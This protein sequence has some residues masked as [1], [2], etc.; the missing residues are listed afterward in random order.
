MKGVFYP[1]KRVYC[2][3]SGISRDEMARIH[4]AEV[5]AA[6][7]LRHGKCS[8]TSELARSSGEDPRKFSRRSKNNMVSNSTLQ[9]AP[10][11]DD[12]GRHELRTV[13]D[14]DIDMITPTN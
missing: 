11:R 5:R 4:I 3:V 10:S 6:K 8:A 1:G 12:V 9:L 13:S 14:L 7:Y 2:H